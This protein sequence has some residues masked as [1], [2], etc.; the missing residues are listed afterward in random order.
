MSNNIQEI[1]VAAEKEETFDTSDTEQVNKARKKEARKKADRLEFIAAAMQ[2]EQGRA[3][4][5]DLIVFC[6]T[7]K[8]PFR[9]DP[10]QTAFWC[11]MQNVGLRI[12]ADL[13]EAAPKEYLT[14]VK[15]N[16]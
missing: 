14:M 5:Y 15:E 1:Q 13:Q 7:Y 2:H 16:N 12:T 11:G 4:F 9:E 3:W 6:K 10:Y 8:A